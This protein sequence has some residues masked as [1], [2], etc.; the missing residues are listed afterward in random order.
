MGQIRTASWCLG[1]GEA[2]PPPVRN[3][4]HLQSLRG[5]RGEEAASRPRARLSRCPSRSR[6]AFVREA[7]RG[8]RTRPTSLPAEAPPSAQRRAA[9]FGTCPRLRD[10]RS[11]FG[12]MLGPPV[13]ARRSGRVSVPGR[14]RPPS[15][16]ASWGPRAQDTRGPPRGPG[17]IIGT[18]SPRRSSP[19][20]T[21]TRAP[22]TRG[23]RGP[24]LGA[25]AA[26]GERAASGEGPGVPAGGARAGR[27]RGGRRGQHP[28][29]GRGRG[30]GG[31]GRGPGGG[32][33][34]RGAG[35]SSARR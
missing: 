20:G 26:G 14:R 31:A 30:A 34:G 29:S 5:S 7:L 27:A 22:R 11:H 16:A 18:R 13:S 1:E 19:A 3:A 17:A 25:A 4:L 12:A 8:G 33:A 32:G 2:P 9:P 6:G 35:P 21:R 28:S 15:R 24:L 10:H 23:P